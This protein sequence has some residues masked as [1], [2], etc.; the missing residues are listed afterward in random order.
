MSRSPLSSRRDAE[1]SERNLADV[2][3]H[4]VC[5]GGADFTGPLRVI[6]LDAKERGETDAEILARI[7]AAAIKISAR[8]LVSRTKSPSLAS[9]PK[10]ED[11]GI[12]QKRKNDD[13]AI[14]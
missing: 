9:G 8:R 4:A 13:R 1:L 11:H 6:A 5:G 2:A 7:T 3:K 10:K 14:E 12:N